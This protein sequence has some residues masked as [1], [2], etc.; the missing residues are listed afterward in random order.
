MIKSLLMLLLCLAATA[1][2]AETTKDQSKPKSDPLA[3]LHWL[4][5]H[6]VGV[7]EGEPGQSAADR[8]IACQ[9]K[10]RYLHVDGQSV[11]PKQEKNPKGEIHTSMDIWSV[12]RRRGA[13]VLRT[14]DNL[15]FVTTYVEDAGAGTETSLVLIAENF[16][17]V[18]AG[19]KARYTYT[20][21]PPDEYRELFELDPNGK[22]FQP[23]TSNRFLRVD[24]SK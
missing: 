15:G 9:M 16:E 17:N 1:S 8:H 7:G 20:F 21:L 19:W 6:W 23:Y 13:L 18:P 11:Y 10:C 12:D 4:Q 24:E 2:T 3:R 14:F 5:G 22:G